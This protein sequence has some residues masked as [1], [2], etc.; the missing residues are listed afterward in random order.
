LSWISLCSLDELAEGRGKYVEIDGF[1]LAVFLQGGKVFA[2]DNVCPHAGESLSGGSIEN[3]CVV[4]PWHSWAF[5]LTDG[6][7]RD[8]PGVKISTY[9]IRLLEQAGRAA[10][11]QADLPRY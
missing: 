7:L 8:T 9:K 11:V 2:L 6:Q 5:Q 1:Q 3:G 4:C 10:V